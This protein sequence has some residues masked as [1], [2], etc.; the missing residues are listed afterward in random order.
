[1]KEEQK[2]FELTKAELVKVQKI[3]DES[4]P[5]RY[6]LRQLFGKTR[7]NEIG[8]DGEKRDYGIRFA[9]S[10]EKGDVKRVVADGNKSNSLAYCTNGYCRA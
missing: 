8:D 9:Q 7:W 4:T 6:T 3:I 2:D 5:W 10:Y 1:M